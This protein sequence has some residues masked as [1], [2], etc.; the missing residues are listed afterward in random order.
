MTI[1]RTTGARAL[2]AGEDIILDYAAH[3]GLH[4]GKIF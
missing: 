2:L 3:S 1:S 4:L